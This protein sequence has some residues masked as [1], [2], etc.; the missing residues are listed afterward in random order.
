MLSLELS[1]PYGK[2][3]GVCVCVCGGGGGA[4]GTVSVTVFALAGT[5]HEHSG[6]SPRQAVNL[7]VSLRLSML[8]RKGKAKSLDHSCDHADTGCQL[9]GPF[10]CFSSYPQSWVKALNEVTKPQL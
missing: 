9:A 8:V 1:Q 2:Q 5:R 4:G 3:G 6:S 7:G 10:E